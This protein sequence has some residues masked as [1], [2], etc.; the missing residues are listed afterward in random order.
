MPYFHC[1]LTISLTLLIAFLM[2]TDR[3]NINYK[4]VAL[5]LFFQL[6]FAVTL[7]K[8]PAISNIFFGFNTVLEAIAK[9]T[10]HA[11]TFVFGGLANPPEQSGLGYILAFQ[12]FPILITISALSSVLTYWKILPFIINIFSML[13]RKILNIG[14][15][16]GFAVS[17]NIFSGMSETPLV[18]N[19]YLKRLTHSEI[20]SLMV[21]GTSAVASSVMVLYSMILKPIAENPLGHILT[22][23]LI[24]I[25]ASLVISRIMIPETAEVSEGKDS[26]YSQA[27]NTL[28]ALYTG[29]IDGGKVIVTILAMLI[30]FIA[31]I[32]LLN[33]IIIAINPTEYDI[34]IQK[35][36]GWI[37]YPVA[38]IIGI[39]SNEAAIAGSLLGT[40]LILN[41]IISF[42]E[43]VRISAVLS[44]KTKIMMIY[45]LCSFANLGS[46]GV[47]IGVYGTLIPE[48]KS[49]VIKL[50]FKAILAGT[51]VNLSIASIIGA[52][53]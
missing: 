37:M 43:L 17:A 33:Q 52:L 13:F 30:G 46:I 51:L 38:W 15:T 22:S 23:V 31:L 29:I 3:K 16:L 7:F 10:T 2:S 34:T 11:T 19:N 44:F 1:I 49:E 20:F 4:T 36:L 35:I 12:G 50:G 9:S 18:I 42:Q 45:A 28:D 53:I 8:I 24:S 32:D 41:E 26:N 40:K 47:M 48:R 39:P 25:P 14:G 27:K 5:G 6:V 21:C